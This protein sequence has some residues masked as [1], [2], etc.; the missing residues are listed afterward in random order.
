MLPKKKTLSLLVLFSTGL[1]VLA[2]C[3]RPL[4]GGQRALAQISKTVLHC[5]SEDQIPDEVDRVELMSQAYS[6]QGDKAFYLF[7][8]RQQRQTEPPIFYRHIVSASPKACQVEYSSPT[9][10]S[11]PLSEVVPIEVAK[12]LRLGELQRFMARKK[13]A[14]RLSAAIAG[15]EISALPPEDIWALQHL[16]LMAQSPNAVTPE[17]SKGES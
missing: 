14:A 6:E 7:R 1:L 2:W 11:Q 15:G 16:G 12:P 8:L 17:P 9:S 5:I 4:P 3:Q 13:I 10:K